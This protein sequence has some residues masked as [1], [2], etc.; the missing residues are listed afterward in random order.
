MHMWVTTLKESSHDEAEF[1]HFA[2]QWPLHQTMLSAAFGYDVGYS[3]LKTG[4]NEAASPDKTAL[5]VTDVIDIK[6]S[7]MNNKR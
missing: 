2:K 3:E 5:S 7:W 1:H 6:N 4:A